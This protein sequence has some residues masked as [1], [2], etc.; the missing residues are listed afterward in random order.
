MKYYRPLGAIKAVSFDLDD[1]LYSNR[2]VMVAA[3][4]AMSAFFKELLAEYS[5]KAPQ[6][7]NKSYW[8]PF[9]TA[10][11]RLDPSLR[12]DVTAIRKVTYQAGIENLGV[13]TAEAAILSQQAMEFFLAKRSDFKVPQES[14]DLL[15]NIRKHV[16]VIAISNGNVDT[17]AIGI[18]EYFDYIYHA[19]N[20]LN[21]KPDTAM[22]DKASQD[23]GIE[24][25]YILHVGDCGNADIVGALRAGMQ[26]AWLSCYDVGKPISVLPHIELTNVVE[27]A[28][29]FE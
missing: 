12:H 4:K 14:L 27:L 29:L 19:G 11:K 21:K 1:T 22:F 8:W 28:T 7:Y 5:E 2:P 18:N 15:T 24:H 6:V 3:E 10:A 16:P 9:R 25:Q 26:T 13:P 20:G 17:D 23:L